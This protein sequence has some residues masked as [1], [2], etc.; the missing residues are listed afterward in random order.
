ME[1]NQDEDSE[2]IHI[3]G[4][5]LLDFNNVDE[6]IKSTTRDNSMRNTE[7]NKQE[8]AEIEV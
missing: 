4:G 5:H 8:D 7:V 1:F 3:V 2:L 6:I